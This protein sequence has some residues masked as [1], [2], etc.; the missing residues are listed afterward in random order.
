MFNAEKGRGRGASRN[1]GLGNQQGCSSQAPRRMVLLL[2]WGWGLAAAQGSLEDAR[3][4]RD[5]G[6]TGLG[7]VGAK[8]W[9][10]WG[11]GGLCQ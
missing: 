5:P 9:R 1:Q 3:A 4:G 6:G 8:A 7:T 10:K 2:C 11:K